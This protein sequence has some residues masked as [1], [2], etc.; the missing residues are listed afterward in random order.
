[1]TPATSAGTG[2]ASGTSN[3]D[4]TD[5]VGRLLGIVASITNALP[6]GANTI[7]AVNQTTGQGKTLLF[8][9]ISTAAS[10]AT[11]LVAADATR[12][13]KVVGY[14]VV[15]AAAVTVKFQSAAVDLTGAMPFAANGGAAPTGQ[16]SAHLFETAVNAALNINLGGAVQVSGHLAYFLE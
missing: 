1:M 13:I 5:R 14:T 10:G 16:P 12:K 9:S 4:V 11:Q 3:V 8:A 6:A 2:P 15:C 7:G